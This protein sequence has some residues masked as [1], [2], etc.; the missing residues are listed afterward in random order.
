MK[1]LSTEAL[2]KLKSY[3]KSA[4]SGLEFALLA[5]FVFLLANALFF[6]PSTGLT[7]SLLP[8]VDIDQREVTRQYAAALGMFLS[9]RL[10]I[11]NKRYSKT[12]TLFWVTAIM[13]TIA[14]NVGVVILATSSIFAFT[15]LL[16]P[17]LLLVTIELW[18]LW[19]NRP[20]GFFRALLPSG[21]VICAALWFS[22]VLFAEHS[23]RIEDALPK[24][25]IEM[26]EDEIEELLNGRDPCIHPSAEIV[27]NPFGYLTSIRTRYDT[28]CGADRLVGNLG[29]DTIATLLVIN[30][31][32]GATSVSLE[33]IDLP[34]LFQRQLAL[35]SQLEEHGE[36]ILETDGGRIILQ[37]LEHTVPTETIVI[38]VP[39][40]QSKEV[41]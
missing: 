8:N 17:L 30:E 20:I 40:T 33:E 25:S 32:M 23:F 2:T 10:L 1:A 38:G 16:V 27:L 26:V 28:T 21:Y 41:E 18:F 22:N 9:I 4:F 39:E 35:I 37:T 12:S 34:Q 15:T 6:E 19:E 3:V 31:W 36:V 7:T 14:A 11:A 24:G 5:S 29:T 13:S